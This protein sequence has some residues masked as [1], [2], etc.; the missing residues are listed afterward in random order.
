[1]LKK[2]LK[3]IFSVTLWY[4]WFITYTLFGWAPELVTLLLLWPPVIFVAFVLFVVYAISLP[5]QGVTQFCSFFNTYLRLRFSNKR[6]PTVRVTYWDQTKPLKSFFLSL[7]WHAPRTRGH[8]RACVLFMSTDKKENLLLAATLLSFRLLF[9]LLLG[10]PSRVLWQ[11]A[12]G[13]RFWMFPR[14]SVGNRFTNFVKEL[15]D[16]IV[17]DAA[18]VINYYN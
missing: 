17:L 9:R 8:S 10:A 13:C 5:I 12:I 2:L 18:G 14:E 15:S 11:V 4:V 3:R 16:A 1:M 7:I 6:L